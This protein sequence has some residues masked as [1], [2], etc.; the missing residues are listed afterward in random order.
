MKICKIAVVD[1]LGD[2][3]SFCKTLI[4]FNWQIFQLTVVIFWGRSNDHNFRFLIN[5]A[6]LLFHLW[7]GFHKLSEIVISTSRTA[8]EDCQSIK[9]SLYLEASMYSWSLV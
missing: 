9:H 5:T 3:F 7:V 2:F 8:N 6:K 4:K 1:H